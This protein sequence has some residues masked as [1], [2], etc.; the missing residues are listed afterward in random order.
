[1]AATALATNPERMRSM[2]VP[3]EHGAWGMLLM[4]MV[5]GAAVGLASG[6]HVADLLLFAVAAL[7]LFWLRTPVESLLGTSPV[8]PQNDAERQPLLTT[9]AALALLAAAALG[10]LLWSRPREGF[11]VIGAVAG[12]AFV[13][14]AVLKKAGRRMRMPAQIIGVAGLTATAPAAYYALTGNLDRIALALWLANWIFAANQV[15]FVQLRI[16][17]ARLSGFR[18]K[19]DRGRWFLAGQIGMV[20]VLVG[21]WRLGTLRWMVPLAFLPVLVRGLRW[22]VRR[23]QPLAVRALGWWEV[24]HSLIFGALLVAAFL[25]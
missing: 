9:S 21:A 2:I 11:L 8:R 14:Q 18:A 1:M 19:V 17:A 20:V 24:A 15:H 23:P 25:L 10:A 3:R 6:Q 13:A 4:P 22:F 12:A 16:H 7:A 5:S